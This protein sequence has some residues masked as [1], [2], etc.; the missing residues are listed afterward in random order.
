[1]TESCAGGAACQ[2][3][4]RATSRALRDVAYPARWGWM[5]ICEKGR[6]CDAAGACRL[7]LFGADAAAAMFI[8]AVVA[9]SWAGQ[10]PGWRTAAAHHSGTW[11][12][13]W[14]GTTASGQQLTA[15]PLMLE[16]IGRCVTGVLNRAGLLIADDD[17]RR[18]FLASGKVRGKKRRGRCPSLP[19]NA[20]EDKGFWVAPMMH[21][22]LTQLVVLLIGRRSSLIA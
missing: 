18:E 5:R 8:A 7:A 19:F 4:Q 2:R 22:S 13:A 9:G 16:H 21:C 6:I 17:G 11:A 10:V 20:E 12:A 14:G 15:V 1:M 3:W